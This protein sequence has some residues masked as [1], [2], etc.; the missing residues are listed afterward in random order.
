MAIHPHTKGQIVIMEDKRRSG[1]DGS[2]IRSIGSCPAA[3]T[4][5]SKSSS[6]RSHRLCEETRRTGDAGHV[7]EAEGLGGWHRP[8]RIMTEDLNGRNTFDK[9]SPWTWNVR[10]G[11]PGFLVAAPVFGNSV[12][13]AGA[14]LGLGVMM[15]AL[16]LH[17]RL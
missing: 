10:R 3:S 15:M 14:G 12:G 13:I 4:P 6:A 7:S 11:T 9:R 8:R 17:R 5:T 2:E 1:T 16:D